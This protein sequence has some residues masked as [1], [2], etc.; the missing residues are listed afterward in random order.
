[1]AP[2]KI[3]VDFVQDGFRF[4]AAETQILVTPET[5][6]IMELSAGVNNQ[7]TIW[8][9][10]VVDDQPHV[11]IL[12]L[13]Y[14]GDD[15]RQAVVVGFYHDTELSQVA[16]IEEIT[17]SFVAD[18]PFRRVLT[19][20]VQIFNHRPEFNHNIYQKPVDDRRTPAR[21]RLI[22][23]PGGLQIH[24]PGAAMEITPATHHLL[25]GTVLSLFP[26]RPGLAMITISA[27]NDSGCLV[28]INE[29]ERKLSGD[30]VEFKHHRVLRLRADTDYTQIAVHC[31]QVFNH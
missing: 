8:F 21:I 20:C 24:Y 13:S 31:T 3:D 17:S 22:N 15:N 9:G 29:S 5:H 4:R 18:A 7:L 12:E 28:D 23:S 2:K 10:P 25:A 6:Q 30:G 26:N 16:A 11:R 1:M 19:H 14:T 27:N